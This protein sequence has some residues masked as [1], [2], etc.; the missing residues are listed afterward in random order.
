M[1]SVLS[2]RKLPLKKDRAYYSAKGPDGTVLVTAHY[3]LYFEIIDSK[4]EIYGKN[5]KGEF[6]ILIIKFEFLNNLLAVFP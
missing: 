3:I 2:Y 1:W 6:K 4:V 5:Q